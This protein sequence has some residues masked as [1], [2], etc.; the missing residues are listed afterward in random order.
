MK[1]SWALLA[2]LALGLVASQ[3]QWQPSGFARVRRRG[4]RVRVLRHRV[5][6]AL[7]L[8]DSCFLPL[9]E[10]D[11]R[12]TL[13]PVG[14][15]GS[16]RRL[17]IRFEPPRQVPLD[18]PPGD[19]CHA[20][21]LRVERLGAGDAEGLRLALEQDGL[22]VRGLKLIGA[23]AAREPLAVPEVARLS[24][25][26]RPLVFVGLDGADWQ[27]LDR[28]MAAGSMPNL[29][30]LV[31]E[32]T[33]GTLQTL[34]PPLSPLVWTTMLTGVSPLEHGVLDFAR[35]SPLTGKK[36]PITS[37]ERRVP[38]IWNMATYAGRR[39]AVLGMWATYPAEPVRGLVVSDRLFS[40]LYK[41]DQPPPGV[42]FPP[43]R[44]ADARAFLTQAEAQ[45]GF[46]E[47]K[48]YL[49][50]LTEAD[51]A[52]HAA[53]ENPYGHPVSALRRILIET[54]VYDAFA[55][56]LLKTHDPPDL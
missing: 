29:S 17:E 11:L 2:V 33:G 31:R 40:F 34:H 23:Q 5:D 15:L 21:A 43:E 25:K 14:A 9:E 27:L 53:T 55:M 13:P 32:G 26:T 39:V 20:L 16:A 41:E 54:S 36:E 46:S 30:A 6:W 51:Y 1:R 52:S 37:D 7:R 18:W 50:W 8:G 3:L 49:P 48:R 10:A 4:A 35:F 47:L 42:V 12:A 44:E 56:Q 45:V 28:F 22:Q 19:F 38:A 24:Q